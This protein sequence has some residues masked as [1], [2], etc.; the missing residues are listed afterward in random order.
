MSGEDMRHSYH[1][2]E[3]V[4][5]LVDS[6]VIDGEGRIIETDPEADPELNP[7][8]VIRGSNAEL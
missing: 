6:R 5:R 4:Q 1:T 8:N 2:I 7:P 3:E